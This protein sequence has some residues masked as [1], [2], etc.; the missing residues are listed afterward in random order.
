MT[1]KANCHCGAVQLEFDSVPDK[2]LECNCSSCGRYG[3]KWMYYKP[4]E[5][6][7]TA[8]EGGLAGYCWGD[9]T[10]VFQ[11]CT[12]CGCMTHYVST[13][14]L[15]E[16]KKKVAVNGRMLTDRVLMDGIPSR[17]FDGRDTWTFF[18]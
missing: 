6:R 18:D 3:A 13:D 15:P 7:V 1:Y 12:N 11:H 17:H 10:S 9:E 4:A 2:F 5:V 14:K 16:D 8:P